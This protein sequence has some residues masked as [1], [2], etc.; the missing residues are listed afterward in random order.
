MIIDVEEA[1]DYFLDSSQQI[2]GITPETLPESGVEYWA[3][4]GVCGMFHLAPWPRV[5]MAHYA[6]KVEAWGKTVAPAKRILA[7]FWGSRQVDRIIGW[8]PETNRAALFLS[9]RLGFKIEGAIHLPNGKII[10]QGWSL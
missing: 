5:W 10:M 3:N 9:R 8:T 2:Q 1:R 7:E 6:V 4:E